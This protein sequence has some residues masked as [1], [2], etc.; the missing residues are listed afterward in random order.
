LG[1]VILGSSGLS[2]GRSGEDSLRQDRLGCVRLGQVK[3]D[4]SG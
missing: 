3:D 1:Y 4:S 2:E